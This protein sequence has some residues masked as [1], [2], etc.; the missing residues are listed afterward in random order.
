MT[1][2]GQKAY[3]VDEIRKSFAKAYAPWTKDEDTILKSAYEE[4]VKLNQPEENFIAKQEARFILEYAK[5][6]GRKPGGI[7]SRITKLLNGE[8][9]YRK[10]QTDL[11]SLSANIVSSSQ[12]NQVTLPEY[13]SSD[14]K[15]VLESLLS[16]VRNPKN[17]FITVGGYAGTGKTTITSV[18]RVLLKKQSPNLS[19]SFAC[20]TGKASIVLKSKLIEQKAIFNG[21]TI[22]TIHSLM[23]K[24]RIDKN[25]QIIGWRRVSKIDADLIIVDEASMVTKDM[26][27][28]LC[29]YNIPIIA[30][31]DHGQLP[32]V[33]DTYSLMDNPSL[34]LETIHRHAQDNPILQIATLA[35]TTGQI[36]FKEF[37]PF[38]KKVP[39]GTTDA[40]EIID[41]I[42]SNFNENTLILCGR[43]TTRVKLNQQIRQK[44]GLTSDEPIIG[45]RVIC[46]KNN[47]KN[48]T[49]PIY[50][51]MIGKLVKLAPSD[52]HWYEAEIIFQDDPEPF[53][54]RIS[55]YQ[56]HKEKY[57]EEV[58]GIHYTE[59]GDRFDF[60]YALT[61]HKSQGSQ[62]DIVLLFEEPSTYW[63]DEL[64]N[65]WLYTAV[66]RAVKQLYIIR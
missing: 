19:I 16:W 30:I 10:T 2:A 31:G 65:R 38:V 57:L 62:A 32:P 15:F 47:Y 14:Q 50:N 60:G 26:W 1:L 11:K 37:S 54:G 24:P 56:F 59:I 53:Q 4:F 20:F 58:K 29:S 41:N 66:T 51:G 49:R 63:E 8:I 9:T 36:P 42:F 34:K 17:G 35:R 18:L 61:V 3:S 45:E 22:G 44:M 21:D 40:Q 6:F 7:R 55:K 27:Q 64:W 5:K 23:Y 33:G 43:N 48:L 13:L 12:F 25:G 46:L 28:D 39:R 52:K